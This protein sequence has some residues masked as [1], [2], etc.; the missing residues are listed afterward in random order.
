MWRD[1]EWEAGCAP[2]SM[3]R[4]KCAESLILLAK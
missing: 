4:V 1:A 2:M 3:K